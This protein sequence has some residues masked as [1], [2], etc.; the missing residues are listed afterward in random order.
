[1]ASAAHKGCAELDVAKL[2]SLDK[3]AYVPW[4]AYGASKAANILFT[5]ELARRLE[6]AGV[7]VTANALCPGLVATDL[8]RYLVEAAPWWQKPI[9]SLIIPVMMARAKGIPDGA[10]TALHLALA[11]ELEGVTGGYF[12]DSAPFE[13]SDL[14]QDMD[15]AARLFTKSE[16]LTG[17]SW[18]ST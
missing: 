15:L 6:A 1:V 13:S 16:E 9:T 2:G 11:P 18:P 10:S 3:E 5:R 7:P 4:G 17:V 14:A 12:V 8:G